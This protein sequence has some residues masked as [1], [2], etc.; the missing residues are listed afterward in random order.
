MGIHRPSGWV[1]EWS[2]RGVHDK[3]LMQSKKNCILLIYIWGYCT[4]MVTQQIEILAE[5]EC[6]LGTHQCNP[7]ADCIDTANGYSCRCKS[8][9]S[10]VSPDPLRAPGRQCRKGI[11]AWYKLNCVWN[12]TQC[13]VKKWKNRKIVKIKKIEKIVKNWKIMRIPETW[14]RFPDPESGNRSVY[15][16]ENRTF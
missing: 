11:N 5:N 10:D 16:S 12:S 9:W 1:D 3:K 15:W 8:G 2:F 6:A 7:N 4:I 13:T 14:K